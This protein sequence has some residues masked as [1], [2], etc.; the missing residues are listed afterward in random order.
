VLSVHDD[1]Q[2]GFRDY[3]HNTT[4]IHTELVELARYFP[5]ISQPAQ[6]FLQIDPL[7]RCAAEHDFRIQTYARGRSIA[8]ASWEKARPVITKLYVGK[9]RTLH[10]VRTIMKQRY[11]FEAT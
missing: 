11:G 7:T 1:G 2:H 4:D 6:G 8:P 3:L 9:G 5:T 10:E